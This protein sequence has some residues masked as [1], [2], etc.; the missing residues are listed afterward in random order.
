MTTSLVDRFLDQVWLTKGLS[1]NTLDAYRRDLRAFE[2]WLGEANLTDVTASSLLDYLAMRHRAGISARTSARELSTFRAFYG[3][4]VR[5]HLMND[6]P[7]SAIPLPKLG[8]YLPATLSEAEV[9][10]LLAV[11]NVDTP[12]GLRDRAMLE[13][14]YATG[15][16]VSEL[17]GLKLTNLNLRQG[18]VR[19]DAGKG[20][21]DRLVPIG[22]LAMD[23]A[24]RYLDQARALLL[25]EHASDV[26][27]PG[28]H[29]A[30]MTRQTFWH[31]IKRH[32][33][34]AGIARSISPHVLRHAFATHLLNHGADLRSVQMMLG[35]SDL[36]TTQIYTHVA[37][38]RL[39]TL[40]E[41]HHPRA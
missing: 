11:P 22:E 8:K 3:Y 12:R 41:A 9:E 2:G 36:S 20:G 25:G 21:K 14:M 32:A 34:A 13:L 33:L 23:W 39:K 29:G 1:Q 16:R 17:V 31:A 28:R 35:H 37:A 15:L 24:L 27:F 18:V 30:S 38:T 19:V 7:T 40:H 4:L 5:E 10:R 6:D 26:L